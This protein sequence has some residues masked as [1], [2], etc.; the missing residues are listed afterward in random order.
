MLSFLISLLGIFITIFLVIGIHEFGHFITA[1]LCGIKVLRFSIGF[2]KTLFR[3]QDKR[4]T[5]YVISLI[6]LGGYV[7]MLD[8]AEEPVPSSELPY[9]YNRQ[10][11]YK[12]IAVI[13]AGPFFNFI[14]SAV[15]YYVLF[16]VGFTTIIPITGNI[17]SNSAAAHAGMKPQEEILQIDHHPVSTWYS[18]V[19]K[20]L[21]RTGDKNTLNIETQ[22]LKSKKHETYSLDLSQWKMDAL[23]PDPLESLGI[24]PFQPNILP[25]IFIIQKNSPAE[26]AGLKIGDKIVSLNNKSIKDWMELITTIVNAPEKTFNFE[27]LRDGKIIVL[28]VTIGYQRNIFY[29]KHGYLGIAP[30]ITYP[31]NLLRIEQYSPIEAFF[32]S[33]EEV[34]NFTD[35]NFI[36]LGKM[37]TGKVSIQSLGGPLTI[38]ESAGHALNNGMIAFMSFLAF[39]SISIGVINILPIPG[40]DGGHLL[41]QLV[42]SIRGKPLSERILLL[43]YRLGLVLLFFLIIQSLSNDLLRAL[44]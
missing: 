34:K 41:F 4:G 30:N 26:H 9:A 31:K 35:L 6:P 27:I 42:E 40:L 22:D 32:R 39:L 5:E 3:K 10:P 12:R 28:P 18:I 23:K 17:L 1:R 44:G 36:I 25:V 2:G 15:L 14:F 7:K 29:K 8:E 37:F 24:T 20:L 13:A 33:A 19:I 38:F 21:E 11:I 43:F 16:V